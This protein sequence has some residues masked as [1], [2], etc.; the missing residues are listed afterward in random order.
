[1]LVTGGQAEGGAEPDQTL[2]H[3]RR[4]VEVLATVGYYG[5][6]TIVAE[7]GGIAK[8]KRHCSECRRQPMV[9][10]HADE[11]QRVLLG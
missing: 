10:P 9:L 7:N 3:Q 11:R 5:N 4:P 8:G 2:Q 1:M 6:A